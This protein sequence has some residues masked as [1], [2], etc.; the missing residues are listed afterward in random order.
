MK[1]IPLIS[2]TG[3]T[4]AVASASPINLNNRTTTYAVP[5]TRNPHFKPNAQAQVAKLN[6]RYPDLKVLSGSI[7]SVPLIDVT[8]DLEYYGTISVGTPA[9]SIKLNFDTVS[10]FSCHPHCAIAL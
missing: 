5:L 10:T 8:P 4:A 3:A 9:Q 1:L 6:K 7:G 2:L